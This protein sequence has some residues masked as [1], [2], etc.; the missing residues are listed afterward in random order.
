ME[1]EKL[2]SKKTIAELLEFGIIIFEKPAGFT[3]FDVSNFVKRRLGLRKTSHFGTLDPMV[4]GVLPIAL[5]RAVKLSGF[6]IGEDKEYIGTM[7][8]HEEVSLEEIKKVIDDKFMGKIIQLPPIRSAVKRAEREREIKKFELLEKNKKDISFLVECQGGTYVR[9][10][11]HDLGEEMKIGAH[12]TGLKR[13]RAGIFT[14]EKMITK[15]D[16]EKAVK[17]YE[18]GNEKL[19][20]EIIIPAEIVSEVYPIIEVKG[21]EQVQASSD[22]V[23]RK[24]FVEK[25]L[26]GSPI[27][28]KFLSKKYKFEK[29][30][31]ISVFND[32]KFIGMFKVVNE[33]NIFARPMFVMQPIN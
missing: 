4:T 18:K 2:K 10:L 7:H 21:S 8:M 26:H 16:F 23:E 14:K 32:D 30:K 9:K 3:S 6:F 33:K 13:I 17:E 28:E 24:N 31:I 5:N 20:R 1:I 27:D 25:I 29:D 12:M 22:K 15:E 11:V 19:L